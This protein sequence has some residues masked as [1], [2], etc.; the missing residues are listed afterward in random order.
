MIISYFIKN[1]IL[2]VKIGKK[3]E[4]IFIFNKQIPKTK[5]LIINK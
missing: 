5:F 2:I 3:T 1:Y 4:K